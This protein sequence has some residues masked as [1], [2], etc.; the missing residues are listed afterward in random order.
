M[1][2]RND[3]FYIMEAYQEARRAFQEGEVP[4]GVVMVNNK[5]EIIL[6]EHNRC[7]QEENPLAHAELLII[8]KAT[9]LGI[10]LE[11]TTLY[12]TME[13]CLMCASAIMLVRIK[14]LVYGAKNRLLGGFESNFNVSVE[15]NF[16]HNIRTKGGVKA[17]E[18]S[19]LLENF[20]KKLRRKKNGEEIR[21]TQNHS[22]NH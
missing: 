15:P 16:Q 7:E 17:Q 10:D 18:C 5:G 11:E 8:E 22:C 20:F 13:P 12:V 21:R 19:E 4:V 2:D 14:R 6:R 9:K 3:E 1:N